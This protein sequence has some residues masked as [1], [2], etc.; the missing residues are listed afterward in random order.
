MS[1]MSAFNVSSEVQKLLVRVL[2][3]QGRTASFDEA[4][5]LLGSIPE[6]DSMAVTSVLTA[7]EERFGVTID[8]EDVDGSTFA[9]FGSLVQFVAGKVAG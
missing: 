5:P 3:L 7:I 9:T 6:L 8:D 4:T 2:G 1:E